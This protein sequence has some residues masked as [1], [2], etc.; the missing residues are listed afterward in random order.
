M[1]KA[2]PGINPHCSTCQ[3]FLLPPKPPTQLPTISTF[4]YLYS[5]IELKPS[6]II[7]LNYGSAAHLLHASVFIHVSRVETIPNSNPNLMA[8]AGLELKPSLTLP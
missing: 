2:Q 8:S 4:Q 7:T 1:P 5:A 3:S 6:L